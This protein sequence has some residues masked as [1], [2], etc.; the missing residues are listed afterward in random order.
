MQDRRSLKA[1]IRAGETLYGAFIMIPSPSIVEM[2][3]YAGFDFVILDREHGPAGLETLEHELRAAE[4]SGPH[5]LVRIPSRMAWEV[6]SVLD[7]GATGLVVPHVKTAEEARAI[8]QAAHYPPLGK[9]GIA[10]TARAGR[11]GLVSLKDHLQR[12]A[13]NTIVMVQI[14]DAEALPHVQEILSTPGVDAVFI[15][16]ADLAMSLGH[17]GE[18]SHPE[19][20]SAINRIIEAAKNAKGPVVASFAADKRAAVALKEKGVQLI[21]LSGT[22]VFS[23]RLRELAEELIAR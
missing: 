5:A 6:L 8:V 9:R 3:G 13:E 2:F 16:P 1:R 17:P 21:C 22:G 15:G 12:A 23:S 20:A 7:A 4:A 19:V 11:H 18:F 14:E 10:T